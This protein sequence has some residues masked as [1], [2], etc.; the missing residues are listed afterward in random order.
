MFKHILTVAYAS[1]I[2]STPAFARATAEQIASA[3]AKSGLP[4]TDVVAVTA[5]TDGNRLLGRP[6]YYVSKADFE[7]SRH[8]PTAE[9]FDEPRSNHI[10]VFV[11]EADAQRRAAYVTNIARSTP[12]FFQYVI[13]RK[14]IVIRLKRDL[15]PDEAKGYEAALAK[16]LP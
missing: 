16:I 9:D 10:E 8:L 4:V 1:L 5:A 11:T 6:G 3:L 14:T 15:L 2:A 13:R 7:D 12:M